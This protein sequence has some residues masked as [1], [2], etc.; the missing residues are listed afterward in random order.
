MIHITILGFKLDGFGVQFGRILFERKNK[1]TQTTQT[2]TKKH[3]QKRSLKEGTTY[4]KPIV[5]HITI[6]GFKLDGFGLQFG[7][8]LF[9]RKNKQTQTTQTT[10]KKHNQ[11][12]SLKEGTTYF[13]PIVIHITI[14]GFKLDGFGLQFGRILFERKNKQTQTTQTTTKKHNQ[15]RSLKEGTT[16]FKPI[17]IHITISGFK[18]DAFGLQFGR[19]LFERKNKQTQTAQTT[20]KKHNQKRSL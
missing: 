10:T 16:Y 11:K 4:F 9:E 15:K 18:L 17:V 14:S 19:I 13:K 5:I 8:I 12:R 1:Q 2:T 7:R 3:N 20:T 6:S